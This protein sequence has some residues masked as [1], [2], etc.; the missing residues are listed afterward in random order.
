MCLCNYW[1]EGMDLYE[2]LLSL[3]LLGLGWQLCLPTS[4]LC[5]IMLLLR[6]VLNMLVRNSSPRGPM[7][8]GVWFLVCQDPVSCYL[9]CVLLPLG[10]DLWWVSCYIVVFSVLAK[11][12]SL[13]VNCDNS[14][15][16][17]F[18]WRCI[19]FGTLQ[20]P[21]LHYNLFDVYVLMYMFMFVMNCGLHT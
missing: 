20:F 4:I 3:S 2:V 9:Y 12:C 21:R 13:L 5:G 11:L 14:L 7:R 8:L 18:H 16:R 15:W 17:I 6:S 19:L 10:T 1:E